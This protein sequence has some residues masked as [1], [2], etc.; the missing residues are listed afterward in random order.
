MGIK[1]FRKFASRNIATAVAGIAVLALAGCTSAPPESPEQTSQRR[2]IET[3]LEN[4][5]KRYAGE[6][7]VRDISLAGLAGLAKTDSLLTVDGDADAVT[8]TYDER[9]LGEWTPPAANDY[10]RWAALSADVI[11][12]AR[13]ESPKLQDEHPERVLKRF[14]TGGLEKL[15][16]YTRYDTPDQA[17]N[18]RGAARRFR[19]PWGHHPLRGRKDLRAQ[20]PSGNTR[21]QGRVEGRRSHHAYRRHRTDRPVAAGGYPQASRPDTQPRRSDRRPRHRPCTGPH[22][23]HPRPYYPSDRHRERGRRHPDDR[24]FGLQ[25]G[26]LPKPGKNPVRRTERNASSIKGIV[27]DLRG[28]PGG[29]LDQAVAVSDFFLND[30]RIISTRGRHRRANQIFDASWGE[31]VR[32]LPIVMLVNGRSASASEIV[33]AALRDRERAIIVGT[34]SYGKGSVQ[35]IVRLPNGGEL[36]LTWAHMIAPSGFNLQ[37]HGVIPAICTSGPENRLAP[38]MA[39]VNGETPAAD[40]ALGAMLASRF[41]IRT[42]SRPRPQALSAVERQARR[43]RRHRPATS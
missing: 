23:R 5:E 38:L 36:T 13:S 42:D 12:L 41:A 29:L 19:R 21:F 2:V 20:G 22:Y 7:T 39:A 37:D 14:F 8:L 9:V 40:A 15:D 1:G 17:R 16:R 34:S 11:A 33:A 28:N 30:G 3:V 27:L 10:D 4:I 43:R 32:R 24:D 25:P 31:R 18:T 6:A 35:T 26:Y